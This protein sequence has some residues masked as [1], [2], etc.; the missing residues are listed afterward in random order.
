MPGRQ[1]ADM[2]GIK[3]ENVSFSYTKAPLLSHISMLINSGEIVAIVGPNGSGKSTLLKLISGL[4]QPQQGQVTIEGISVNEF[5]KTGRIAYV[6]QNYNRN[7]CFP[8]TVSEIVSLGLAAQYN[9]LSKDTLQNAAEHMLTLVGAND[10]RNRRLAD[11]SGGQQ[12]RVMIARA[13]AGNPGVILLDEPTSG[14][15]VKA[16]LELYQLLGK[17]NASLGMTIIMVSHD[18]DSASKCASRV[19]CVNYGLC[20]FGDSAEFRSHHNMKPHSWY[21]GA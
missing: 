12:Q 21:Y 19:A 8:A 14:I 17:L 2:C 16:S 13:L 3:I 10:F 7:S 15:D 6:P 1:E 20:Y 5:K 18:I 4:L 11:L 9:Y